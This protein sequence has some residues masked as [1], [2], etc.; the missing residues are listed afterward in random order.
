MFS[1]PPWSIFPGFCSVEPTD[2]RTLCGSVQFE[3]PVILQSKNNR[4]GRQRALQLG[5]LALTGCLVLLSV[6]LYG[7][8]EV[9]RLCTTIT[10]RKYLP[11]LDDVLALPVFVHNIA[12]EIFKK[13]GDCWDSENVSRIRECCSR[14]GRFLFFCFLDD[15]SS[16]AGLG[17]VL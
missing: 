16:H 3:E 11:F 15:E 12:E 9:A 14:S 13:M 4:M 2:K 6:I 8:H 7:P 10:E 5:G 1:G 17:H